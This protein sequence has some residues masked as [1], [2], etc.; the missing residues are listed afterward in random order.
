MHA[1]A[2]ILRS[3]TPA[4]RRLLADVRS[5]LRKA[6]TTIGLRADR[7]GTVDSCGVSVRWYEVGP[8]DPETPTVV[9]VHGF[10]ISAG[11]FYKQVEGLRPLGVRQVLVDLRGHGQTGK[12][13]PELLT[14]DAAADD[15]AC[16][17]RHRGVRGP[18]VVVGHSLGGPVSLSL[19]R[20]YSEEFNWAGSVQISSA[21]EPFTVQGMPQVLAGP[22]GRFLEFMVEHWPYFAEGVRRV[23][24]D[25]LAPILALGFYF[26][27]MDYDVI[28]FHAAMIQETPL[29]TYAG[30]FEDLL[31][32]SELSAAGVLADL[33]GYILV[34][35]KDHVTPVSQSSRLWSIWPRAYM[36]VLPDSG[37][38]PPLDAPGAV[39]AAIARVL[40]RVV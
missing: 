13:D 17:L 1:P 22:I 40:E 14:I 5:N 27:P 15:V 16:A 21:V 36:Q 6:D 24:T 7:D 32:H 31:H 35:D 29:A 9:Y 10:N 20:R 19:M 39:T 11:E 26:R 34:G 12:C 30:Y 28:Q 4:G 18:V 38:M 37:H 3:L 25:T 23:V 33:P 2:A 8:E